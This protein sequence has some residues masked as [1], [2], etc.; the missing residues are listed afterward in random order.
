MH[1]SLGLPWAVFFSLR[2]HCSIL[3]S[4]I[5]GNLVAVLS[6]RRLISSW[7]IRSSSFINYTGK[8]LVHWVFPK[9]TT[10]QLSISPCVIVQ[11]HTHIR[12]HTLKYSTFQKLCS[13]SGDL[14][15]IMAIRLLHLVFD[16]HRKHD[17]VTLE[18]ASPRRRK[19]DIGQSLV[20]V[21][22]NAHARVMLSCSSC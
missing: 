5:A 8:L 10:L 21:C 16:I 11:T 20:G 17:G 1:L 7:L 13:I 19:L 2:C 4:L 12:I 3:R 22:A 6:L 18:G 9:S 14:L 15:I